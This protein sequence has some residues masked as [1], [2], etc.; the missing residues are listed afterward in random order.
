MKLWIITYCILVV[1]L[2]ASGQSPKKF[3]Q[4]MPHHAKL[5]FA[6]SIGFLSGGFGYESASHKLQYDFFYGYVPEKVGGVAIHSVTGKMT[7]I[8]ISKQSKKGLRIDPLTTGFLVNYTFGKQ[9]FLF[10]TSNYPGFYYGFPTAGN[11]GI[12]IG[13]SIKKNKLGL[14]Y[15]I[16]THA[17]DLAS[18]VTNTRTLDFVD[19]LNIGIG[20]RIELR[21]NNRN[22]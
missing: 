14:Y 16:G 9:Y 6:G 7:W 8:L 13:S 20:A 15:E 21:K 3:S 17:K 18:Y 10:K 5:Q 19:I 12:F 4:I 2:V 11:L 22:H 1:S